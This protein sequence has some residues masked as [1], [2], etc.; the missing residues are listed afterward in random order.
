MNKNDNAVRDY[1]RMSYAEWADSVR[2][3]LTLADRHLWHG[4]IPE[5]AEEI[6]FKS[7]RDREDLVDVELPKNL[8]AIGLS[9][10]INCKN[11][12]SVTF[13]KTLK[14]V[15]TWAF[16]ETSL[17]SIRYEGTIEEFDQIV[18]GK[19]WCE[20]CQPVVHCSNGD[21]DFGAD[22]FFVKT[23]VFD[24]TKADWAKRFGQ[25]PWFNRRIETIH[26]TDGEIHH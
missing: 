12:R 13:P 25:H 16:S 23:L 24:G 11:L 10:F 19:G 14:K 22:P 3:N 7:F 9:A 6:V 2:G 15:E 17:S 18:F 4:P 21:I 8:T 20:G 1:S 5:S 26:C